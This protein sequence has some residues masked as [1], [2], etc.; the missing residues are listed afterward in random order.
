MASRNARKKLRAAL[1]SQSW[2]ITGFMAELKDES[3]R[4]AALLVA[5]IL[6]E[7]MHQL[8]ESYFVDDAEQSD[9]MLGPTGPLATFASRTRAAY[10]LGLISKRHYSVLT[11][12]RDIRNVF[13]HQLQRWQDCECSMCLLP[14]P[15]LPGANTA[16]GGAVYPLLL[17]QEDLNDRPQAR[18]NR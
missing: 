2:D 14:P 17:S 11:T 8:L 12:L 15:S 6:D 3:D 10:L 16:P 4:G 5:A 7:M 13:A 1:R 9:L 18:G